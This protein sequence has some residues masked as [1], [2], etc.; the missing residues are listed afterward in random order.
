MKSK[1]IAKISIDFAMTILLLFLMARQLTGDSAHEWLG[2]GMFIL[3]IL[4]NILNVRWH[5]HLLNPHARTLGTTINETAKAVG[6]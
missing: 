6:Y 5:G 4:H 2:T 3:W 1:Q